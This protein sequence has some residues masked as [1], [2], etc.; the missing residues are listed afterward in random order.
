MKKKRINAVLIIIV[1]GVWGVLIVKILNNYF[2]SN[3]VAE[4]SEAALMNTTPI[5][6]EIK[7]DT[8]KLEPFQRD[9]FLN[10]FKKK[11]QSLKK[12]VISKR[13]SISK[14]KEII[15]WPQ[16]IEYYGFI[17]GGKSKDERALLRINGVLHR[18]KCNEEI[19]EIKIVSISKESI[20]LSIGTDQKSFSKK[21]R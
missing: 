19:D 6:Y 16:S 20:L 7:K 8:F 2:S 14:K 10:K 17:K 18:L 15:S 12:P 3:P 1:L 11:N 13:A 4:Y 21:S 9:P 5:N